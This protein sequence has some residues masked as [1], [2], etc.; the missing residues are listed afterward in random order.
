[1]TKRFY[2]AALALAVM[3]MQPALAQFTVLDTAQDAAQNAGQSSTTP[4][5]EP[6]AQPQAAPSPCGNE[7]LTI[8]RMNWPSASLLAEI[9]AR[10]V[11]QAYGCPT[12]VTP[13]DLSATASSMGASGQP[14]VAPEMWV[15]R[16]ADLW[17][18][19]SEAQMVRAAAPSFSQT[20]LEGWFMPAY[21][22]GAFTATPSAAGLAAALPE[23]SPEAKVHFISC[24][25][26]WACAIINRNLIRAHGLDGLLDVVE[27]ANRFEMD[28]LIAEAV[29]RR[30]LFVFYYWQ[31]N[32]VLAQLDFTALDMGAFDA[33]AM[34]CLANRVCATPVPSAFVSEQVVTALAERVFTESPMIAS[35]FQRAT[36]PLEEMNRLL[37]QLNEPGATP[38]AV[39]DRFAAERED[40]WGRWVGR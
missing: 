6:V 28:T 11:A 33:T 37:A 23:L 34:Q 29:S 22:A 7:P 24:P 10:I 39:A 13:G 12:R 35:Y 32:A 15:A 2:L 40:V 5:A 14:A 36:M 4:P 1:M 19:A 27:P 18:R 3:A 26:D 20:S 21:M 30:D 9:H 16:V 17:N 25:T 31:P 38:E 8:A